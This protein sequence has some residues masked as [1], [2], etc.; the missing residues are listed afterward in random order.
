MIRANGV[1]LVAMNNRLE[2]RSEEGLPTM[3]IL[4][5]NGQEYLID[6]EVIVRAGSASLGRDWQRRAVRVPCE[7]PGGPAE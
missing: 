4:H 5:G 1:V 3:V 2:P 7:A 6:R